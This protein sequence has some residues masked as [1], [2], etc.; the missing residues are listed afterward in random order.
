MVLNSVQ[1]WILFS[2]F[3]FTAVKV[4]YTTEMITY[5]VCLHTQCMYLCSWKIS[6]IQALPVP[7]NVHVQHHHLVTIL[8]C[9]SCHSQYLVTHLWTT[10]LL[11]MLVTLTVLSMLA[12]N[13]NPSP[14]LLNATSRTGFWW[15]LTYSQCLESRELT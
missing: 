15:I 11:S 7:T 1:T 5:S 9:N 14:L 8:K 13:N 3:N 10:V 4:V 6:V 2:G 12:V